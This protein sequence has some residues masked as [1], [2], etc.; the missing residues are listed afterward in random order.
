ME[1][2][3]PSMNLIQSWTSTYHMDAYLPYCELA[4]LYNH[5]TT[6]DIDLRIHEDEL[7]N[8]VV[9]H[10]HVDMEE[11]HDIKY[12]RSSD[13]IDTLHDRVREMHGICIPVYCIDW[14]LQQIKN[15]DMRAIVNDALLPKY[16]LMH[17]CA[18]AS[19]AKWKELY[20]SSVN[21]GVM[22]LVRTNIYDRLLA[23]GAP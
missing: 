11:T 16:A 10:V 20:N 6:L 18:S 23:D 2:A 8:R 19:T 15:T 9:D 5:M 17:V 12:I 1:Y 21:E 7:E 14:R 4:D 3:A 22:Q 13:E